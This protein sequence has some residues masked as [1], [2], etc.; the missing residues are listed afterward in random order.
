MPETITY[1]KSNDNVF[2]HINP[3]CADWPTKNYNEV[4]S[5]H[6]PAGGGFC[7]DCIRMRIMNIEKDWLSTHQRFTRRLGF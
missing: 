7:P 6:A 2:W 5:E 3:K 1:R 4:I